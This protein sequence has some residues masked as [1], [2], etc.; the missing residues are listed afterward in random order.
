MGRKEV[1][2]WRQKHSRKNP[3]SESNKKPTKVNQ[4]RTSMREI[5]RVRMILCLEINK[6]STEESF[7]TQFKEKKMNFTFRKILRWN[8]KIVRWGRFS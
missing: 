6:I 3:Q 2:K 1:K 8:R 4:I 7:N 5:W